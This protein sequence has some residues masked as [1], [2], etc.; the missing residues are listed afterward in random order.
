V[1]FFA[2]SL[3]NPTPIISFARKRNLVDK[4]SFQH[5]VHYCKARTPV[6]A[7]KI[8]KASASS[9]RVKYKFGIQVPRVIKNSIHLDNK[10][11]NNL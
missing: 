3:S 9:T 10:N 7:A 8:H 2:L 5:L 6:D 11:G 1:N 4:M